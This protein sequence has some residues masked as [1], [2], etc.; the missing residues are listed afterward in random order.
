MLSWMIN[1]L[2]NFQ[3]REIVLE[4]NLG[5]RGA[6]WMRNIVGGLGAVGA[7]SGDFQAKVDIEQP[8]LQ[9]LRSFKCKLITGSFLSDFQYIVMRL[10]QTPNTLA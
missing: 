9:I 8:I 6:L 1:F 4:Y 10:T 7:K 2:G 3:T 5:L